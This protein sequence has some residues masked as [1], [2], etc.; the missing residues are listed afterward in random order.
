MNTVKKPRL[1]LSFDIEATGETP[2]EGSMVMLGVV[3]VLE[4]T[5]I[6]DANLDWV[7]ASKQ[8]CLEEIKDPG[9]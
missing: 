8:W 4:D 9:D 5:I 6:F 3:A 7:V 2:L 1:A